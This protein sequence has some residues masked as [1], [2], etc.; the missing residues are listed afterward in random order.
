MICTVS[1]RKNAL[2]GKHR[3]KA[4]TIFTMIDNS[5]QYFLTTAMRPAWLEQVRKEVAREMGEGAEGPGHTERLLRP[6]FDFAQ[7]LGISESF[8]QTGDIIPN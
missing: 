4:L 3:V 2:D 5:Q 6:R 7:K 8:E 1:V